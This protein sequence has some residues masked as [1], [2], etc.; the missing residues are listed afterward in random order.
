[1]SSNPFFIL[2]QKGFLKD[3][4]TSTLG[5]SHDDRFSHLQ[6]KQ[7][8]GTVEHEDKTSEHEEDVL[9]EEDVV[10]LSN[11]DISIDD[12]SVLQLDPVLSTGQESS[13]SELPDS[14]ILNN[15]KRLNLKI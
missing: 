4:P 2:P 9:H 11:I 13:Q 3:K 7:E 1:M 5:H 8:D 6:K 10:E 15:K 12:L 14:P